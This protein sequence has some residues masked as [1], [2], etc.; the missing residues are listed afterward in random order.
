MTGPESIPLIISNV[1]L[2]IV[3]G[4]DTTASI[5]SNAAYLLMS[6]PKVYKKLQHELDITFKENHILEFDPSRMY[7]DVLSKLPY[8]NAVMSVVYL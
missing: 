2:A 4:S 6:H 3:A 7:D 5:L 1:L 8:L